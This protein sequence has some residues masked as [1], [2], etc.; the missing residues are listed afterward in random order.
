MV[1]SRFAPS[2]TGNL[3]IGGARTALFNYL[4]SKH[5]NGTFVLRI[6]DTD[7]E[8]SRDEYVNDILGGLTWLGLDWDEGPFYQKDRM[9][10]YREYAERLLKEGLAYKCY[11]TSE[12]LEEKRKAAL[13]EGG[14]PHYDRTCRD[15]PAFDPSNEGKPYVIRFRTPVTGEVTFTDLIRGT[16]TFKCEELDD[17]IILRTD[18]TPTYNF[19]VVI[20]DALMGITHIVRG[21]DHINNTPR[22][23]V[24]YEALKFPVPEFAHVP[25]IHGKDKARLSKR[26]GAT[27][28]LE[29]R[30][31]GF[32]P[33]AVMNY[34][35]RLGWAHG[36]QEIFS[37]Q[38]L[39]EKFDLPAVGRSPSV[40]DMDKLTWLNS[41]Y[42][43][44]LPEDDIASRLLPFLEKIG[45]KTVHDTRLVRIVLNLRERAKTLKEMAQMSEYFFRDDHAVDDA[46]RAKFLTPAAKPILTD[47][48]DGLRDI[49]S[50][51]DE[52]SLKAR[53]EGL[54]KKYNAKP[55]AVIQPIRVALCGRTVSPGI[56]DVIAIL[57]KE[58][59]ERRLK[60]A[61][62]S[63]Q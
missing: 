54:T 16:I 63:I 15:L 42:L 48:A 37:R 43:K 14:K 41:H 4:Y 32:L 24:I 12:V 2:P 45:I 18:N 20:D 21:D 1:R 17:L 59:V 39:I 28:L 44:T 11:C 47:F 10:L 26:H 13:K 6:E 57:G 40:F 19:T 61:I 35:A 36:D 9:G 50:M 8:R 34:L 3:H 60:R 38:E 23:I 55:V 25:L 7:I 29:Y 27:S 53:L 58:T 62:E 5:H 56:F 51:D 52:E 30:N 46:A 22:Q 33:E 31:E 49:T